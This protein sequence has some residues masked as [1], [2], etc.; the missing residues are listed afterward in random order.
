[1][2]SPR[3][4][5]SHQHLGNLHMPGACIWSSSWLWTWRHLLEMCNSL[6]WTAWFPTIGQNIKSIV[7]P[8]KLESIFLLE[9]GNSHWRELCSAVYDFR[10][11]DRLISSRTAWVLSMVGIF[12]ISG[13]PQDMCSNN[14]SLGC[15]YGISVLSL[16]IFWLNRKCI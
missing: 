14:Y 12:S 13:Q 10:D 1:M 5:T 6:S 3:T 2:R 7:C 16:F 11:Q 8:N 9:L 15:W 4:S